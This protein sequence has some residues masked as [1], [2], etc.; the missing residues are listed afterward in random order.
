MPRRLSENTE[1]IYWWL[2]RLP[3]A[4]AADIVRVTGLKQNQVSNALRLGERRG[5]LRS[6]RLGREFKP[7]DRF[8]FENAGIDEMGRQFG[9][10]PLWWHTAD[11]VRALARRLEV[12]ELAYRYLPGFWQSNAV[13]RPSVWVYANMLADTVPG[14]P[15]RRELR[16]VELN[17]YDAALMDFHWLKKD[18][19]E[20]CPIEAIA[21]YTNGY[22]SNGYLRLPVLWRG[23]FQKPRDITGVR[24]DMERVL[25][26]DE[27]FSRL[28]LNQKRGS[29][30]PG[31]IIFTPDRVSAAMFQRHWRESR[32]SDGVS[33]AAASIIDAQGQVIRAMNPPTSWWSDVLQPPAAGDLKDIGAAVGSLGRG[34]YAAA[35]GKRAWKIFRATDGSPGVTKAQIAASVG[36]D[37]TVAGR[38]LDRMVRTKVLS[39]KRGDPGYYLDISGRGLLADSQRRSRSGVKRRW[40]IYQTRDGEYT[41][42]QSAHNQGQAEAIL[43]LRDHGYDAF[44]S[45]GLVIDHRHKG[46]L[47]RVTPDAFVILPPGVLVPIEFERTAKTPKQL[48]GKAAKYQHLVDLGVPLP[49]L[50]IMDTDPGKGKKKLSEEE[51][52]EKSVAA[53]RTLAE[54]GHP[55]LLATTLQKAQIGPHGQSIYQDGEFC[56]GGDS[57]CWWYWYADRAAPTP[58]VPIDRCSQL[59]FHR[60]YSTWLIP[61]DNP[62]RRLPS[63]EW[64]R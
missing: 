53:A 45:M 13:S 31:M 39:V 42:A 59:Y 20:K 11:G 5:W 51:R 62:Y 19:L 48:L 7:V 57:G 8:V 9:W 4:A 28:P 54:L 52:E 27:R 41:R 29:H 12:L 34:A 17:W 33:G 23:N 1:C 3:W 21:S 6:A 37:T 49:V 15:G 55:Y 61:L 58:N 44:P 10:K 38:L 30:Y 26:Q 56:A 36:V 64:R 50:F 24:E 14:E 35:N 16:L 2:W 47:F 60:D 32:A 18:P 40:G 22:P 63:P 46:R 43:A 25:V